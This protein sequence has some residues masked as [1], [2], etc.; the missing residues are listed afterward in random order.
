MPENTNHQ[1]FD[2]RDSYRSALNQLIGNAQHRLWFHEKT[3]EESDFSSRATHDLLW[4][5][6]TRT[7]AGTIRILLHNPDYLLN[8]CPRFMQLR[9]R[10]AHLIEIRVANEDAPAFETAFVL[11]D[12]DSYLKRNHF[13]WMRGETGADGRESAILEHLFDQLWERSAPPVGMHGLCV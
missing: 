10:F 11:A 8:Q 1:H 13:N 6:L 2:S 5:F 3:L 9:E 7:P 12:E 4:Q